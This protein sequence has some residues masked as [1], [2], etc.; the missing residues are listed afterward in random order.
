[1]WWCG[2]AVAVA[3]GN[4]NLPPEEQRLKHGHFLGSAQ[5]TP[6]FA[7]NVAPRQLALALGQTRPV[8]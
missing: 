8:Q 5:A 7:S 1:M 2:L 6:P 4:P 3:F